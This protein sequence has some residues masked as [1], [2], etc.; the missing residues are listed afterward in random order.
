ML[1]VDSE[2][3]CRARCLRSAHSP[4]R[5]RV[6]VKE[7]QKLYDEADNMDFKEW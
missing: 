4:E 7:L 3:E 5:S 1:A 6:I 2:S